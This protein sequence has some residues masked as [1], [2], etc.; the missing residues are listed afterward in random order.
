[1]PTARSVVRC[2][3]YLSDGMVYTV[4]VVGTDL[5]LDPGELSI[6][7]NLER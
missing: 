3:T 1:M 2:V 4:R 6:E 5:G 7:I